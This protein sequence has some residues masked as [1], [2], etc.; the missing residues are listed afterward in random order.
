VE[1][2]MLS[3][4]ILS[5]AAL[6]EAMS[7]REGEAMSVREGNLLSKGKHMSVVPSLN[8]CICASD[9]L[10]VKEMRLGWMQRKQHRHSD[11]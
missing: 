9:T 8:S 5:V 7:V 1:I 6:R 4:L 11:L 10:K 2:E 3:I